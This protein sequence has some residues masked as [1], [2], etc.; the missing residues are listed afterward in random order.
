MA[1]ISVEQLKE[2]LL[3]SVKEL[4]IKRDE[5]RDAD[6]RKQLDDLAEQQKA[7]LDEMRK[8][9]ASKIAAGEAEKDK[10]LKW[11]FKSLTDFT[12][13]V[14]RAGSG[15]V[16]E[17]LMDL[18][19]KAAG[20]GLEVGVPNEGGFLVP[21]EFRRQLLSDA[22]EKSN[23]INRCTVI[24]MAT[25]SIS[26]PYIKDTTHAS[27][28][29]G[30]VRMYWTAEEAQL[31][32]SKPSLGSINLTLK[33][34]V[35][36]CYATPELLEDS[37]ISVEP[38]IR[39]WF[40]DAMAW[41]I[42][43]VILDGNGSGKPLGIL[44]APCLVE[45]GKED[46]QDADTIYAENIINMEARINPTSDGKAIYVANKDTFP[47]LAAMNIKVGTAGVPVWIPGNTISG[48]PYQTLMGRELVFS[49]HAETL[50][51]KG[52]IYLADFGQYLVGQKVG[53]GLRFDTSIHLKFDYDQNAYRIIFRIDGQPAWVSARTPKNSSATVS[54]FLAL[55]AR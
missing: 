31:T 41:T 35:G 26:I 28:V 29:F 47:Q 40:T 2:E 55:E 45:V 11:G 23:F 3:A 18:E 14:Y 9:E 36:M 27:T 5:E 1:T 10:D 15:K 54:P 20:D 44:N 4:Q 32:S 49:E 19:K 43:G 50:G 24:P 8:A 42:D 38:L 37:P 53:G 12:K 30:G 33:K 22:I 51:D 17:R 34:L 39:N 46:G 13:A 25:N 16:D 21:T 48:K 7:Q 6:L 52:D